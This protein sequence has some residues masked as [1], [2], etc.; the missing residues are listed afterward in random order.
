MGKEGAYPTESATPETLLQLSATTTTSISNLTNV[1]AKT[2][3]TLEE[4]EKFVAASKW[5]ES[6]EL[7]PWR[8]PTKVASYNA[9]L[10]KFKCED[11]ELVGLLNQIAEHWIGIHS[12]V[13][14]FQCPCCE[15]NSTWAHSIQMHLKSQHP[16]DNVRF[17]WKKN[18][19]W[20][21]VSKYLLRL[22]NSVLSQQK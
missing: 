9:T 16:H 6:E 10:R 14:V 19:V 21:S 18:P 1:P 15:F 4:K 13:R 2:P 11:C 5:V 22:K 12:N 8:T 7:L 20:D 3:K 17:H